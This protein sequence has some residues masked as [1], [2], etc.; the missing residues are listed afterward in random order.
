MTSS[1]K[2]NKSKSN[3][4]KFLGK[5]AAPQMGAICQK[6]VK[7][8]VWEFI[9]K[10]DL[11]FWILSIMKAYVLAQIPY[12]GKIWKCGH[13]SYMTVH[14]EQVDGINWFLACRSKIRKAKNCFSYFWLGVVKNGNDIL[15]DGTQTSAVFQEWIDEWSWFF[16][17]W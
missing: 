3:K 5:K 15:G 16:V 11:F 10:F 8:G 1:W 17:C 7:I 9:E 4:A 6:R 12:F 13:S 14:V 2:P